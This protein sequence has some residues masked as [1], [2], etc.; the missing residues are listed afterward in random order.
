MPSRLILIHEDKESFSLQPSEQGMSLNGRMARV[1][2]I[3]ASS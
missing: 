2:F 3:S 1:P